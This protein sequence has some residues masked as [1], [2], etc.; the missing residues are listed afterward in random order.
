MEIWPTHRGSGQSSGSSRDGDLSGL[1]AVDSE[2]LRLAAARMMAKARR[3]LSWAS[4]PGLK[5]S[6]T[7]PSSVGSGCLWWVSD[8]RHPSFNEA[9]LALPELPRCLRKLL[10]VLV[11]SGWAREGR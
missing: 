4:G 7:L 1:R 10:G 9:D 5:C 11:Q 8:L 6:C 2:E 3:S